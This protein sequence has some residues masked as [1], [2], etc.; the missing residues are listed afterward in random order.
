MVFIMLQLV[1][2]DYQKRRGRLAGNDVIQRF[3]ELSRIAGHG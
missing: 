2:D 1:I 3:Q